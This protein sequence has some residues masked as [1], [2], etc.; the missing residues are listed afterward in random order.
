MLHS[1]TLPQKK[2]NY[3]ISQIRRIFKRSM[4]KRKK[5]YIFR[6]NSPDCRFLC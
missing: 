5:I 1:E 3:I 4:Q 6:D 2:F